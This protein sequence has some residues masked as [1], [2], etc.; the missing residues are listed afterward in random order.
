VLLRHLLW[1]AAE[2]G[3]PLQIHTGFGDSDL[4]LDRADPALLIAFVQAVQPT[5]CRLVLLHGYPYHR[6]AGYLAAV[7]PHVYADVGL[8]LTHTGARAQAVLG[9][10][11]ELTPFG[12][13]LFS[14]DAYGLP[15]LYLVGAEAFR[16]ALGGLLGQWTREGAWS[17]ADAERVAALVAADNARRLYT[18]Q[19]LS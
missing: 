18:L 1:R 4:R 14:T 5:G 11:L 8:T 12:K 16:Q 3:L 10:M 19:G 13:L 7:Y 2:T 15:E 6:Q 17:R 9:E